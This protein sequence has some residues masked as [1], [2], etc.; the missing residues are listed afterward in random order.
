MRNKGVTFYEA[1]YL[2]VAQEIKAVL[3]TADERF[4]KKIGN[5]DNLCLLKDIEP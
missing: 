5:F 3:V 4:V 1:A 2:V